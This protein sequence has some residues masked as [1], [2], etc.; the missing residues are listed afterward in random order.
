[1]HWPCAGFVLAKWLPDDTVTVTMVLLLYLLLYLLPYRWLPDVTLI[2]IAAENN[3][4]ETAFV[5][6]YGTRLPYQD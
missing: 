5:V 1:M 4:S 3:L 2:A 6:S